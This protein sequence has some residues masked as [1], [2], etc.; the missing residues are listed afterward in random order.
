MRQLRR[1]TPVALGALLLGGCA[2]R[3]I[4]AAP[5]DRPGTG[6]WVAVW[7]AGI[8]A[9]VLAGALL[10]LPCWPRPRGARLATAMLALQAG[11]ATVVGALLVGYAVRS[12]QLVGRTSDDGPATA[13]V[14]ISRIDGDTA[15]FSLVVLTIVLLGGLLVAVLTMGARMAAGL[16]RLERWVVASFLGIEVLGAATLAVLHLAGFGGWPYR[17]GLVA[18]PLL[19]AALAS[20]WPRR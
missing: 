5:A 3:G 12:W 17:S 19:A 4:V 7:A 14:R 20:A 10:T 11:G 1:L 16:D 6:A 15:L 8:L 18:L 9:A 2:E 13:L